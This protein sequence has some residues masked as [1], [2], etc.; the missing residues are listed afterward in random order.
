[1]LPS[2]ADFHL[3]VLGWRFPAPHVEGFEATLVAGGG[4]PARHAQIV[5]LKP[6][7][8]VIWDDRHGGIDKIWVGPLVG[9]NVFTTRPSFVEVD[10]IFLAPGSGIKIIAK[11]DEVTF[12]DDGAVV[13]IP[14]TLP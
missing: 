6:L 13:E 2:P 12:R 14:L 1:M 9:L 10:G 8:V 3:I 5:S 7:G 4:V 11:V